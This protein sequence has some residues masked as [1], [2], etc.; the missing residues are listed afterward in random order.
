MSLSEKCVVLIGKL[1]KF[2]DC[3]KPKHIFAL[4]HQKKKE[5]KKKS[6]CNVLHCIVSY[7]I[8]LNQKFCL[9]LNCACSD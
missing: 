3:I 5:E 6:L 9:Q 2:V 7:R 8:E 1:G 4:Y